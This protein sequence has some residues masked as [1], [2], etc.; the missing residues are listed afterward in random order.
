MRSDTRE[1]ARESLEM[2]AA[3]LLWF[4]HLIAMY[5][6][7]ALYCARNLPGLPLVSVV[8]TLGALGGLVWLSVNALRDLRAGADTPGRRFADAVAVGLCAFSALAIVWTVLPTLLVPSCVEDPP[9]A[10]RSR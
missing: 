10:Q 3:P 4:A 8:V 6:V 7:T 2:L 5:G 9:A 1:F